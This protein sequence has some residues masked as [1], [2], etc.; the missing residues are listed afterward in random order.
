MD[1][2]VVDAVQVTTQIMGTLIAVIMAYL[3]WRT[4]LRTPRQES[5]PATP[6]DTKVE[7]GPLKTL[8]VFDTSKQQTTL[9]ATSQGLEYHLENKKQR[10]TRHQWTIPRDQCRAILD[11]KKYRVTP[12]YRATTG[13]FAVGNRTNWLY[14]K[15]LFPEA[16]YLE[17]SLREILD[18]ASSQQGG[19]HVR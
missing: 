3:A 15:H 14:S 16:Q 10:Q 8:V 17:D 11:G 12:G 5:E 4:Y 9:R 1:K 6:E 7:V 2:L 19:G 13:L 18:T